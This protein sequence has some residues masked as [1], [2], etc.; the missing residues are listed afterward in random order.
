MH[1]QV[2]RV[3]VEEFMIMVSFVP[4]FL[5]FVC[6]SIAVLAVEALLILYAIHCFSKDNKPAKNGS[7]SFPQKPFDHSR[8]IPS[9]YHKQVVPFLFSILLMISVLVFIRRIVYETSIDD[10]LHARNR[11]HIE[12]EGH[13]ICSQNA[14]AC[15]LIFFN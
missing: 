15:L 12:F 4:A 8:S 3:F 13:I 6:G 9:A 7:C 11:G 10:E 2:G 14:M 5:A 1:E